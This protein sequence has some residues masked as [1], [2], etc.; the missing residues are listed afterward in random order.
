MLAIDSDEDFVDEE[1]GAVATMP[2]LQSTSVKG[3]KFD[4]PDTDRFAGDYDP[5]LSEQIFYIAVTQ[6]EAILEPDGITDDIRREP[7]SFVSIRLL[8]LPIMAP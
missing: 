7:L 5:S 8:K 4:T 2:P 3:S 6:V 1:N